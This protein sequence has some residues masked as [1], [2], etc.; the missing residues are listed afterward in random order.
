MRSSLLLSAAA[1]VVVA[2]GG[3]FPEADGGSVGG[4]GGTSANGGGFASGGGGA[5]GGSSSTGG[6][7]GTAGG[8]AAGGGA[9]G[10]GE[11][12]GGGTA[13]GGGDAAGGGSDSAGGGSIDGGPT[14]GGGGGT[15]STDAGQPDAGPP[16]PP[17]RTTPQPLTP[18]RD[19]FYPRLV[20]ALDGSLIAS[21][22]GPVPGH[23]GGIILRSTDEGV[24]F[25]EVGRVDDPSFGGGLCCAGLYV[26]PRAF[27]GMPAGTLLWSASVGG[28]TPTA[29]MSLP[30]FRSLDL[31]STWQR[32]GTI[33]TANRPRSG[34]G[35]WEPEF[36]LLDDGAL[37]VHYSD[38][39]DPA[40]SQ[41]LVALRSTNGLAWNG[42]KEIVSLTGF[43]FRPGMPVVRKRAPGAWVM[44]YEICG[45]AAEQCVAY[46][47]T[48]PDGWN[49]G[50]PTDRGTRISTMDGRFFRHAPTITVA[51]SPGNG[52]IYL[53]GQ[54]TLNANGSVAPENGDFVMANTEG[55][56]GRW[57]GVRA[58]V[59]VPNPYNNFCPNYSTTIVPSLDGRIGIS[60]ASRY[61]GASCRAYFARGPLV[62]L[63][64][65]TGVESGSTYRLVNL[66]SAHCLDVQNGSA[67]A[68]TNVWQWTCNGQPAQAWTMTRNAS[69]TWALRAGAGGL[70]LTVAGGSTTPGANVEQQP[71]DGSSAQAWR[72]ENVGR[73]YYRLVH[74]GSTG[75]LDVAGGSGAAGA[76]VQQWSCNDLAP[77]IW[78]LEKI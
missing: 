1:V 63:G 78:K 72:V 31:G 43:A 5:G 49:W 9:F 59:P 27:G 57:Y 73:G 45:V 64:D 32:L 48:S 26:L 2:C 8:G 69:G 75:C 56:V 11:A 14:G 65:D 74:Q 4:G 6:G 70:C 51:P 24:S 50:A 3:P 47:R 7:S 16:P 46:L 33:V 40:H 21:V 10:G 71:C 12:G 52:R 39:T 36:A 61:D 41:K 28:D 54:M 62:G 38:E 19:G 30:L 35:L 60:I 15:A 42:F 17:S 22:V 23:L 25:K 13:V 76:N 77:Q 20:R 34:G 55:G 58:P 18:G 66:I 68:G 53:V 37:T 29:P 67:A 44:S